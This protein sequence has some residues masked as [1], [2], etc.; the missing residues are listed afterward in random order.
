MQQFSQPMQGL[1]NILQNTANQL[2][3]TY[4]QNP[5]AFGTNPAAIV[6]NSINFSVANLLG[7]LPQIMNFTGQMT[8]LMQNLINSGQS[9][10][11]ATQQ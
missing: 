6:Q 7:N 2:S 1:I 8:V 10:R 4:N 3:N 11:P 5:Q 9:Y